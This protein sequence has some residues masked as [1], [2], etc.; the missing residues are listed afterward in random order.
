MNLEELNVILFRGENIRTEF[1]QARE[2]APVG[3]YDTV[4]SFLN[5][6]GGVIIL[7]ADND[8]KVT[9]ID[10]SYAEQLKKDIVTALNNKEVI[11]PPANF[12]LYQLEKE[13]VILLCLKIPVSSQVHSHNG[14]IFDRENDSDIRID[15]DKTI[16]A[17]KVLSGRRPAKRPER[18]DIS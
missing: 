2:K 14:V 5:R 11:N 1:K 7:G 9:G 18:I 16:S 17:R 10:P 8:G 6:E 13:G 12:P 3:L 15:Q 4:V